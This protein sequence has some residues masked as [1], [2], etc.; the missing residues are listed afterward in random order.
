MPATPARR[1]STRTRPAEPETDLQVLSRSGDGLTFVGRLFDE[2][3]FVFTTDVNSFL[4]MKSTAG[5]SSDFIDFLYSMLELTA[6][7]DESDDEARARI[8]AKFDKVMGS[9]PKLTV[10]RLFRLVNDMIEAAGND[11][12]GNVA[13]ST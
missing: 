2:E 3:D 11:E 4:M 12:A 8:Q 7:E 5:R 10:E 6:E 1:T 13:T 9:Q